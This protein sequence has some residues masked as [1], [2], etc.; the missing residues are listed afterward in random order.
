MAN[1]SSGQNNGVIV[2]NAKISEV[3]SDMRSATLQYQS[4]SEMAICHLYYSDIL[5]ISGSLCE[6]LLQHWQLHDSFLLLPLFPNPVLIFF[7][8]QKKIQVLKSL[9]NV[10]DFFFIICYRNHKPF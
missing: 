9:P 2:N 8:W 1:T 10:N 4:I 5:L 6:P 7:C 3:L